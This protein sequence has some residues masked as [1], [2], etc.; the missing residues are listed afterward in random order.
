M[1]QAE[2]DV[3]YQKIINCAKKV[4]EEE[5]EKLE[6]EISNLKVLKE[7]MQPY[8]DEVQKLQKIRKTIDVE[9]LTSEEVLK[10]QASIDSALLEKYQEE[11]EKSFLHI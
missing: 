6:I 7:E 8:F 2:I 1:L 9:G 4:V 5:K 3:L 10:M 11:K